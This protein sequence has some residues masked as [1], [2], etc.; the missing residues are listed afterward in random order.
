MVLRGMV[1]EWMVEKKNCIFVFEI[2]CFIFKVTNLF[3]FFLGGSFRAAAAAATAAAAAA[4]KGSLEWG[5]PW[6]EAAG[7]V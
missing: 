1:W 3:G 2:F 7:I 5:S 6:Q 4:E